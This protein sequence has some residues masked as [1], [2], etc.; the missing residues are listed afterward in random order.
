MTRRGLLS[1]AAATL[2]IGGSAASWPTEDLVVPRLKSRFRPIV[3]DLPPGYRLV[4]PIRD[5]DRDFLREA[6]FARIDWA[7][8][9]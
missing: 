4:L 1:G 7:D 8:E 6:Y 9:L 2:A 3:W 5:D